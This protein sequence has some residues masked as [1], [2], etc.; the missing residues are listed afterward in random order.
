MAVQLVKA[1]LYNVVKA[2]L[3]NW[4]RHGCITGQGMTVQLVK[5]WL[6]NLHISKLFL[7]EY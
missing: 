2:W 6:Y 7:K 3:Y 4:S 5:A 1:W